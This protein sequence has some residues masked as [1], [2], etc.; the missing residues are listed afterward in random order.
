MYS[1]RLGDDRSDTCRFLFMSL[2]YPRVTPAA[3]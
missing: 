1:Q 3:L 2:R